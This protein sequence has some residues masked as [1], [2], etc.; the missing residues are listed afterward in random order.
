MPPKKIKDLQKKSIEKFELPHKRRN[1][2]SP[3][4][5]KEEEEV[6]EEEVREE[7]EVKEEEEKVKEEEEKINKMDELDNLF[8]R[9]RKYKDLMN[10]IDLENEEFMIYFIQSF[11]Q[12]HKDSSDF[13]DLVK[14]MSEFFYL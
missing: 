4:V 10:Q 11:L 13:T 12:N 14:E 1:R 9:D 8:N 2:T 6:R 3:K 7:E 5:M